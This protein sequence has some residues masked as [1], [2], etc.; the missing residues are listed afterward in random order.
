MYAKKVI[1]IKTKNIKKSKKSPNFTV[2]GI[3][4]IV[5]VFRFTNLFQSVYR[6]I[7]YICHLKESF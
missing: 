2:S 1:P 5:K 4:V 3:F 7:P 6:N